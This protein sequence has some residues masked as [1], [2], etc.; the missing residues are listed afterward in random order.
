MIEKMNTPTGPAKQ[1]RILNI[2]SEENVSRGEDA[3]WGVIIRAQLAQLPSTVLCVCWGMVRAG[4][5][6]V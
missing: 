3:Q 5:D 6:Q 2:Y 1:H 4:R